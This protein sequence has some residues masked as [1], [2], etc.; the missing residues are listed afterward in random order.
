M[1]RFT[2][3]CCVSNYFNFRLCDVCYKEGKD[4][5]LSKTTYCWWVQFSNLL[6]NAVC[7]K[8]GKDNSLSKTTYCWWVQFSNFLGSAVCYKEGK[9]NFDNCLKES[10]VD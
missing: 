8:E 4:N 7:Y 2:E 3:I 6:G 1:D 10:R 5:S 9:D